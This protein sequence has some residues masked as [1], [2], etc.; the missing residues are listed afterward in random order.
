MVEIDGQQHQSSIESDQQR[1]D[2]LARFGYCVIRI[3]AEDV[4]GNV[5]QIIDNICANL[6]CDCE[7]RNFN[8]AVELLEIYS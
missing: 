6:A 2:R 5:R 1:D 3:P 8:D 7:Q 4:K